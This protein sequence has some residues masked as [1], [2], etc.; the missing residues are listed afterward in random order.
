M[1]YY[2]N[3]FICEQV[4]LLDMMAFSNSKIQADFKLYVVL[5]A[6]GRNRKWRAKWGVPKM[7]RWSR[8]SMKG[9]GASSP[10]F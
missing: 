6:C 10:S 8:G 1:L 9:L 4:Q 5:S 7:E 2:F 3:S